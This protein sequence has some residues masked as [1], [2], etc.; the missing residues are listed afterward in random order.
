MART[1]EDA[2]GIELTFLGGAESVTGS[3]FLVRGGKGSLLVDC[4]IEQGKD[5]CRACMYE[6]FPFDVPS[7]NALIITHAHLDH[8]GRAPK[9]MRE[10]FKGKVYLTAPTLELMELILRDSA[11]IMA[12]DAADKGFAP[13]YDMNDVDALLARC[14]AVPLH[15]E[16]EAAPGLSC[17][18]RHT[19]HILGSSSVRIKTEDG[20][21]LAI[22]SDLGNTPSPYLP[23]AEPIADADVVL[24]ESVYGDRLHTHTD[25]RVGELEK[26]LMA[27]INKGGAILIPAFS[28]ERSQLMLYEISNLMAAGKIPKIPV[29]LDSPLAIKATDVYAKWAREYFKDG[30]QSELSKEGD[31]FRFSHLAETMSREESEDIAKA[32]S[33]KIIMAGA[34]MS[35]GGR[36]SKW[37]QKYLPDPSTT[38]F[39][40]GYQ[41]PGS[42]GRL[43]QDGVKK[44]KLGR[45]EVK[46]RAT[47]QTFSGWSAHA[48]RDGLVE[49]ARKSIEAS[50]RENGGKSRIKAIFTALGE[51]S[52]QRFLAQRIHDYLNINAVAPT[53]GS[54][55]K[56][57]RDG[58]RE[59]AAYRAEA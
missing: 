3:N 34:G 59:V 31:I 40:V 21:A 1:T 58:V 16:W 18:L 37:E 35:H 26:A 45:D 56:I 17:M 23:D 7:T 49:F 8:V 15:K 44:I 43:L 55:W 19:G 50:A 11:R 47:V 30:V 6:P 25:E 29:F 13:L 28:L 27:A 36:I 4:G 14:Q 42:P 51:P 2:S 22:T 39:M 20:T 54:C 53:E 33:P 52:A 48:D 12:Q 24:M 10:G 38:L 41:A 9:L 46:V 5:F 32:P 57:T